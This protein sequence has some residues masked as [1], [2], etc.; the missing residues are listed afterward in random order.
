LVQALAAYKRGHEIGSRHPNWPYPSAQWV[1]E[2]QS[3]VELEG[4]LPEI[5]R[6]ERKPANV[7]ERYEFA[8]L[9]HVKQHYLAAARLCA[10]A[11]AADPK[12]AADEKPGRRSGAIC[13]AIQAAA[14]QGAD[15]GQL[16][17]KAC[18]HWR[19]LALQ[20]LRADLAAYSRMVVSRKP[21]DYRMVR[22]RL[23]I[24]RCE[25]QLASVRDPEALAQ[26]PADEQRE[27]RLFWA[28]VESLLKKMTPAP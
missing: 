11:F 12:N 20:W 8:L 4:Q 5:V 3:L 19:K 10:D 18:S 26:L 23:G 25:Q 24:W 13:A 2:C 7:T 17:R 21:E 9:C 27:Y 1:N 28:E 22:R 16:D 15:A 14:G 6:G